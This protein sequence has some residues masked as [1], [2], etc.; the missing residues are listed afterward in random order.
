MRRFGLTVLSAAAIVSAAFVLPTSSSAFMGAPA[1]ETAQKQNAS[2]DYSAWHRRHH[3][4]VVVIVHRRHYVHRHHRRVIF[5]RR[6][7]HRPYFAYRYSC[8][9]C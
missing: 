3:R 6:H 2:K 7:H 1:D 8:R 4:R 5:V 9:Y